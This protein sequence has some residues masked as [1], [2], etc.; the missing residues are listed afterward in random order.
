MKY[1]FYYIHIIFVVFF[2]LSNNAFSQWQK[3]SGPEGG[4]INTIYSDGSSTVFAAP[5]YNGIY[6]STDNGFHWFASG[7]ASNDINHIFSEGNFVFAYNNNYLLR[8]GDNGD[9]W[10]DLNFNN[11]INCSTTK[12]NFIFLG[13]SGSSM[14]QDTLLKSSDNGNSWVKANSGISSSTINS[15]AAND[16]YLFASV[17]GFV[18][19]SSDTGRSWNQYFVSGLPLN[20]GFRS[21][22]TIDSI[23][24][25]ISN[26]T[27]G[28]Y[29]ST[30]DGINWTKF[31]FDTTYITSIVKKGNIIFLVN[32]GLVGIKQKGIYRSD[33]TGK[34]WICQNTN[35]I[36][37]EISTIANNSQYIFAGTQL[38]VSTSSTNGNSW[39][40][41]NS[42]L[43]TVDIDDIVSL[44]N[45]LYSSNFGFSDYPGAGIYFSSNFGNTWVKDDLGLT[46]TK[47]DCLAADK[48]THRVYA[49]TFGGGVFYK[50][51]V[52]NPWT[53]VNTGL[54][55]L[56]VV[57]LA[58]D[59]DRIYAGMYLDGIFTSTDGGQ[60][61]DNTFDGGRIYKIAV[62]LNAVY[63]LQAS[64]FGL[65]K[66][67][68]WKSTDK[69]LT[70]SNIILYRFPILTNTIIANGSDVFWGNTDGIYRS[71]NNG[72]NWAKSM[73]GIGVSDTNISALSYFNNN[74]VAG[75]TSGK[76]Y[77]SSN[78]GDSW[79]AF[80]DG[81]PNDRNVRCFAVNNNIL[82]AGLNYNSVW[83]Y[84]DVTNSTIISTLVPNKFVLF[85]NYPNPFN[86]A[87]KIRFDLPHRTGIGGMTTLKIY[88][89]IG[90]EISTL[91]NQQL[92]PGTYEVTFDGGKYSSGVYFYK[93]ETEGFTEV[94]RMVLLK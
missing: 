37:H 28:I 38:G 4:F 63:A 19:R 48:N 39:T 60:N 85:Q 82:F 24:L 25:G 46:L 6:R 89:V 40:V 70:W 16:K 2:I 54:T 75:T 84:G 8:S 62:G 57:S 33:D 83:R 58:V 21:M 22:V 90:R 3:T 87:T 49:G 41:T 35:L 47:I 69:G 73:S 72:V 17:N 9:T 50:D 14:S 23:V 92:Q 13:F 93:I 44:D 78:N 34:S 20:E 45:Y 67:W 68:I 81:F 15:L 42:G 36:S 26:S 53:P 66:R 11:I 5:S 10:T 27:S 86:P 91:I 55:E 43:K 94:K 51:I 12:G 52:N 88:D 1:H 80:I 64:T 74:I 59:V 79:T 18:Y 56:N 7:L 76:V 77:I 71:T 30:N 31:G 61:W 32:S 65:P 29:R